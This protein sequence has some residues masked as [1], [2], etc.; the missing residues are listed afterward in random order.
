MTDVPRDKGHYANDGP[1]NERRAQ[2]GAHS[3]EPFEALGAYRHV[4]HDA[5]FVCGMCAMAAALWGY[6]R[7]R[8]ISENI[9]SRF[10]CGSHALSMVFQSGVVQ[11]GMRA[12][13]ET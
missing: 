1:Q 3:W 4:V 9:A 10:I 5:L 13:M 11:P 12:R 7:R 2:E 6:I 8:E